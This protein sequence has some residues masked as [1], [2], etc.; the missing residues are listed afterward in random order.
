ME[1]FEIVT[2]YHEKVHGKAPA[3][4]KRG[5]YVFQPPA[6]Y[7]RRPFAFRDM[8]YAAA[9]KELRAVAKWGGAFVLLP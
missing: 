3:A 1:D 2:T 4:N 5:D 9:K 6:N 8:S 7:G